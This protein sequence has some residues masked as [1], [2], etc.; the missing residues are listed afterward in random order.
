M[1]DFDEIYTEVQRLI[2]SGARKFSADGHAMLNSEDMEAEGNLV[3]AKTIHDYPDVEKARFM[4]IFKASLF[5][6]YKDMITLHRFSK[7]H[8]YVGESIDDQGEKVIDRNYEE[9]TIDL[10]EIADFLG[11]EKMDEIYYN[12]YVE[13]IK[14]ILEIRPE[15][16][17]LF[18]ELINPSEASC[19]L[20]INESK[21]K[22]C[23]LRQGILVRGANVVTVKMEHIQRALGWPESKFNQG[24][25]IVREATLQVLGTS[26]RPLSV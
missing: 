13:H 26:L 5:N 11:E 21:R 15:A 23:L 24:L 25:A 19:R 6:K 2:A 4:K 14:A 16:L 17:I 3:F 22:A 18:N 9:Y 12:N 8:G 1:L 7:K 10:S 20:A